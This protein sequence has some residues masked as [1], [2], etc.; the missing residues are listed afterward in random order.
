MICRHKI[1]I[2]GKDKR[3]GVRNCRYVASITVRFDG[4]KRAA[5][6]CRRHAEMKLEK[7]L[8]IKRKSKHQE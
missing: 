1:F 8:L 3:D 7:T 5:W 6:R 2:N 4:C